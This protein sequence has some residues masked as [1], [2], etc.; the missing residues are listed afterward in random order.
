MDAAFDGAQGFLQHIGYF[1]VFIPVKIKQEGV[2]ENFRQMENGLLYFLN[3]EVAYCCIGSD[4]LAVIQQEIVGGII[5]NHVL[6]GFAAIVVD[7]NIPHNGVQPGF[8]ICSHIVLVFIG[9][10]PVQ[11]F[12]EQIF[13]RLR[14]SGKRDGEWF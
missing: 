13:G 10:C 7:K 5:K 12:L 14:I 4:R 2:F 9:Q 3:V 11:G 8:D 6:L 1:M